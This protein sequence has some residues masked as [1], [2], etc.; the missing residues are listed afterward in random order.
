MYVCAQKRERKR[1]GLLDDVARNPKS[2]DHGDKHY[3]HHTANNGGTGSD[4]VLA[5]AEPVEP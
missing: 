4:D 1:R 3:S 5:G 2:D